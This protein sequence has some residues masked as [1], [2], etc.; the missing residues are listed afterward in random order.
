[1]SL[2]RSEK[3]LLRNLNRL[4]ET[5]LSRVVEELEELRVLCESVLDMAG[6]GHERLDC[7]GIQREVARLLQPW[8]REAR[9]YDD[10]LPMREQVLSVPAQSRRSAAPGCS[11]RT[12]RKPEGEQEWEARVMSLQQA[13]SRTYPG[14]LSSLHAPEDAEPFAPWEALPDTPLTAGY[15]GGGSRP[16]RRAHDAA[17]EAQLRL[18]P[19]QHPVRRGKP[20]EQASCA[21]TWTP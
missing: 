13:P 17:A 9:G 16:G 3:K 11:A 8:Q 15:P 6:V 12:R 5:V 10:E 1:M 7:A 20:R 2:F 14:M 19:A 18:H 21:R 4:T